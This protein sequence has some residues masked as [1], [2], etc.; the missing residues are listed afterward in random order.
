ME[1]KMGCGERD[2]MWMCIFFL[3]DKNERKM[4]EFFV[5][6]LYVGVN[7]Y[8]VG[9]EYYLQIRNKS[10]FLIGKIKFK[11]LNCNKYENL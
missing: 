3:C 1:S 5:L 10:K 4:N 9:V 6:F 11:S 7:I 2:N 8:S